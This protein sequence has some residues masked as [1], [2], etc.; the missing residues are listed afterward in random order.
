MTC[1]I[2]LETGKGVIIGF[3]SASVNGWNIRATRLKKVFER[4]EFLIGYTSSFRMGQ[5]LQYKLVVGPQEYAQSDLEYLATVFVDA[6]R[7]CLKEGGFRKVE[8]EQEEGGQ[9]LVSY[10]G[11][12]YMV[13]SDF[14]VNTSLD[15]YMAVGCGANFALGSMWSSGDLP[16]KK[17]VKQA[18][19]A[20]GHFSNGVCGPYHIRRC[21]AGG[22][23]MHSP[24]GHKEES[25]RDE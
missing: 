5:L 10:R 9:F 2:G 13:D 22:Q 14:Q 15:G 19:R 24:H 4:D 11:R 7:K 12:L 25:K 18:L 8:D 1:I 23:K 21:W 6:V 17:R 20:A 16:P 3:D